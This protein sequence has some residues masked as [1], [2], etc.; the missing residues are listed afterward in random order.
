[1]KS[2]STWDSCL[3]YPPYCCQPA[4]RD[5]PLPFDLAITNPSN[6]RPSPI[7]SHYTQLSTYSARR[8]WIKISPAQSTTKT[9]FAG[10]GTSPYPLLGV[11][12][13]PWPKMFTRHPAD[14]FPGFTRPSFSVCSHPVPLPRRC[15]CP[16][17]V[18]I[19]LLAW[20]RSG[21]SIAGTRILRIPRRRGSTPSDE[22]RAS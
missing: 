13:G 19:R 7:S 22:A 18:H 3:M 21:I 20:G 6:Y 9:F 15:H 4:Q 17:L 2:I 10:S 1:V 8:Q 16:S 14:E 12:S 5:L 11:R